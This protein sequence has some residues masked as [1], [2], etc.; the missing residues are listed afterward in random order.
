MKKR[1]AGW[2]RRY[3]LVPLA[4][5]A[6]AVHGALVMTGCE[7]GGGGS[8]GRSTIQGNVNTFSVAGRF[9]M[10]ERE[11]G[12]WR[13]L[14]GKLVAFAV[15]TARAGTA[16]VAVSVQGTDISG[17]TDAS[18]NFILS[19]VPGGQQVIVFTY[20]G[21]TSS[22]SLNVPDYGVVKLSGVN[23]NNDS[24]TV[25]EIEVEEYEDDNENENENENGNDN[26]D[27]DNDDNGNDND[28][29]EDDDNENDN[30]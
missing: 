22:L 8:S 25:R 5:V 27:N 1:I 28:D 13:G 7:G 23:V 6:F 19:G 14:A 4:V 24:V 10:P 21:V 2:A 17:T 26:D 20:N 9:Y 15:P 12:F 11:S 3:V 30:N 29:D 16:G 18:G